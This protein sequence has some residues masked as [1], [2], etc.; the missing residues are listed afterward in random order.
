MCWVPQFA[1]LSLLRMPSSGMLRRVALV[2]TDVSE[3]Y[4][5]SIIR[6]RIGELETSL[7]ITSKRGTRRRNTMN[8]IK[9]LSMYWYRETSTKRHFI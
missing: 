6:V 5:A 8:T 2:R 3:E 4:V 9:I 1:E 7:A